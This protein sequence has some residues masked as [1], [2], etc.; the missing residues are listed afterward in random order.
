MYLTV[1]TARQFHPFGGGLTYQS[2]KLLPIGCLVEV[3]LRN[4]QVEGIVVAISDVPPTGKFTVKPITSV[5]HPLPLL[6]PHLLKTAL[7]MCEYYRCELR[8][9]LQV[10]LPAPP[11]RNALP[12]EE[13]RYSLTD[14]TA[15]VRGEKQ[16]EVLTFLTAQGSSDPATIR[17]TT[18]ASTATIN[19]LLKRGIL[20]EER[21]TPSHHPIVIQQPPI[22]DADDNIARKL[23]S[24]DR[25]SLLVDHEHGDDRT[26]LYAH[27][28]AKNYAE[29]KSTIILYPDIFSAA[30]AHERL[31]QILGNGVLLIHSGTGIADRRRITR[32][33]LLGHPSVIIGTRTA[34]FTPVAALGLVIVDN[35]QEWT[36]KSEQT[37]RY[38]TRLTAEVLCSFVQAKLI[39]ASVS[40][41]LDALQHTFAEENDRARYLRVDRIPTK[42]TTSAVKVLDLRTA[43]F[44][45]SY[46]ITSTLVRALQDR[47]ARKETSVLLLNRKGTA[48][49]L[50]CFDC[51]RN[52]LS[53]LSGLPMSVVTMKGKQLLFDRP[54]GYRLDLPAVC[55][56]CGSA[57]LKAVGSGTEGAEVVLKNLLPSA[58]IV[59][60][61]ADSLDH[62]QEILSIL[63]ALDQGEIDIL[64]GTQPVLKALESPRVTLAAVLIADIGFSHPDFRAGERIFHQLTRIVARMSGRPNTLTIVQTFRPMALEID[65]AANGKKEEYWQNE[66]S[67]RRLA[68]YPP[69]TQIIKMIVRGND[70]TKRGR[71][72]FHMAEK[73]AAA[74]E[75]AVSIAESFDDGLA[76]VTITLRGAHPR[77][78]LSAL[79]LRGVSIDVDP[80]E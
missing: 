59:R 71:E 54:T 32:Q 64:L 41:S 55:P 9:A 34:L 38:H 18:G 29:K 72:L 3:P 4:Q 39:L 46:P 23:L 14:E 61:D 15:N 33:L 5:L 35:E 19:G 2:E 8:Q 75:I 10:F 47:I 25:P 24:D 17:E 22:V 58:R 31:R 67:L 53:P 40:P 42:E 44:G 26:N 52:V 63:A 73:L 68:Q 70:A 45:K 77:E 74:S 13:I 76:I 1:I 50:L 30:G 20:R 69:A 37:P 49:S 79:P 28:A 7:W 12:M 51:Q 60:V 80:T 36:Y 43:N 65:C 66:L 56:H 21:V 78:L 6:P 57:Q 16:Q 27:L 62:P 11:W 48:T